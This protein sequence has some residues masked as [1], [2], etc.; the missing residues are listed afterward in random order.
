M[1]E[2][3]MISDLYR[4]QEVYSVRKIMKIKSTEFH[5]GKNKVL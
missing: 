4:K 2:R 3:K 1:K 5:K